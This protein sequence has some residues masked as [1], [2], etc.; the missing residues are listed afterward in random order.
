MGAKL[1]IGYIPY[2]DFCHV[3]KKNINIRLFWVL[4]AAK[5]QSLFAA[6]RLL[7]ESS[8]EATCRQNIAPIVA[9]A[10]CFV[11]EMGMQRL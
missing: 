1:F 6:A 3:F 8:F 4:A 2:N 7:I 9:A 11:S 5:R 10:R